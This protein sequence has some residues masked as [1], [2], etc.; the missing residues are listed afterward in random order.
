LLGE[1]HGGR[2]ILWFVIP[3]FNYD[4]ER[5]GAAVRTDDHV[6]PSI[7]SLVS[8]ALDQPCGEYG[9]VEMTR[10]ADERRCDDTHL[11]RSTSRDRGSVRLR[12]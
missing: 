4:V 10:R 9:V 1:W 3:E 5:A 8:A 6:R 11:D 7:A 12:A 2:A